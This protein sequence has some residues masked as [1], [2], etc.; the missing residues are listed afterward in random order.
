M[1]CE[2]ILLVQ[3]DFD[4]EL[5]A[6][7][8]AAVAAH[9]QTCPICQAAWTTL[10]HTRQA[11]RA[12]ASYHRARPEFRHALEARLAADNVAAAPPRPRRAWW[13]DGLSFG[14]GAAVAASLAFAILPAGEPGLVDEIVA[15]HV[16]ALQPGHLMDVVSTDRHTVK[17]WFDG[18][19]DFAPPVRDFAND[20]FPLVGGRLDVLEGRTAAALVYGRRKHIVNVFVTKTQ[21]GDASDSSGELQGY[22]WVAWQQNGFTFTAVSDTAYADLDQLKQLFL[23][24]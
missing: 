4:G 20:G 2:T 21:S 3:A 15:D 6:A 9:R 14:L 11:V 13:R 1:S 23:A 10:R 5:D 16:R 19:L 8:A 17:P 12:E 24:P 18:K 7:Q 22:H